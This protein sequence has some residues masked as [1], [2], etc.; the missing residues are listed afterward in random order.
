MKQGTVK[1]ERHHNACPRN[2]AVDADNALQDEASDA[3]LYS[4]AK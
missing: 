3:M 4:D 2:Q 1:S